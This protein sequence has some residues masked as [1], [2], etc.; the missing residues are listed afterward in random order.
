MADQRTHPDPPETRNPAGTADTDRSWFSPRTIFLL[1]ALIMLICL[2]LVVRPRLE[3]WRRRLANEAG[4]PVKPQPAEPSDAPDTARPADGLTDR[5]TASPRP[6]SAAAAAPAAET[7]RALVF[8]ELP[9]SWDERLPFLKEEAIRTATQ[10][11]DSSPENTRCLALLAL[12]HNR[13]GEAAKAEQA[14]RQC[15]AANPRFAEAYSGL[16]TIAKARGDFQEAAEQLKKALEVD[17]NIPD[18][19]SELG[20]TLMNLKRMPEAVVL[21]EEEVRRFP[22]SLA[23]QYYLGQAHLQ[24]KEYDKAIAPFEAAIRLDPQCAYAYYGLANACRRLGQADKSAE[25][26]Q[27]FKKFKATDLRTQREATKKF[28]DEGEVRRTLAFV[29]ATAGNICADQGKFGQAEAHWLRAIAV[30][31]QDTT[32][33]PQLILFYD[34]QN[35]LDE[36][37][38]VLEQL[39]TV[40]PDNPLHC[41]NLG[42]AHLRRNDLVAAEKAYRKAPEV[43]PQS[44]ISHATL[45]GFLLRTNRVLPEARAMAEKAVELEPTGQ[46]YAL[47]SAVCQQLGDSRAA[48]AAIERAQSLEP[49]NRTYQE[50][51]ARLERLSRKNE[52]K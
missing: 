44:A 32:A 18:V 34:R 11:V 30:H 12:T 21:L 20:D 28:D 52:G 31:P 25:S 29:H 40:E 39:Q 7:A 37:I 27:K 43:A 47:L 6:P 45:A 14:W 5:P 9:A 8:A 17:P 16:G 38:S 33:R 10:L 23:A 3:D 50:I 1:V 4:Q 42:M 22:N 2:Y 41:L 24:L 13:F 48:L 26:M 15:L 49:G 51:R 36:A 19:R 35:R 46:Y